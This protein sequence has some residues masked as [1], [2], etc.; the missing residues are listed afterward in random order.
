MLTNKYE[1]IIYWSQDDNCFLVEVPELSGCMADMS[2]PI[3]TLPKFSNENEELEFWE[4]HNSTAY[5]DWNKAERVVLPNL[6]P[7]T[8]TNLQPTGISS[9]EAETNDVLE[10][11]QTLPLGQRTDA[12]INTQFQ[13]LRDEWDVYRCFTHR[14][15]P[16]GFS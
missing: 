15:F 14:I 10:F 6:K 13:A 4:Q 5:L 2:K 9:N 3:K 8:N 16:E 11:M 7:T 12:D 1:L